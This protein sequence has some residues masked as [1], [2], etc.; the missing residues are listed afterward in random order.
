LEIE[1]KRSKEVDDFLS[2]FSKVDKIIKRGRFSS[3][4]FEEIDLEFQ[5]KISNY[6]RD[7]GLIFA[8]N[9]FR[10]SNA[11]RVPKTRPQILIG[12]AFNV[13]YPNMHSWPLLNVADVVCLTCN[14]DPY[15]FSSTIHCDKDTLFSNI[16]KQIPDGFQP[17]FYFDNQIEHGHFIPI[18]IEKAPFPIIASI[19]HI[20]Y[21]K[22]IGHVCE[23]FDYI[24]PV[25]RFYADILKKQYTEKILD[26]PFG[27]NWAAFSQYVNPVWEKTID[28]NVIF[29][30]T[31]SPI[32]AYKRNIV[33]ELARKF[34]DKYGDRFSIKI[35][36]SLPYKDY[37][38]A[39]QK[40][41]ITVNAVGVNGSY[42]YRTVEAMCTGSMVFQYEYEKGDFFKNSFN[43]L[44][45]DG[46]HG[47]TFNFDN[48]ETKLLYYLENQDITKRIAKAGYSYL[49]TRLTYE[50]LYA[51]LI[52]DVKKL[53]LKRSEKH[54]PTRG[55]H[56]VAM[57]YY[58][59]NELYVPELEIAIEPSSN[60]MTWIDL[61]N[62]MISSS[63]VTI[64]ESH[65]PLII[66]DPKVIAKVKDSSREDLYCKL[67]EM[68]LACTPEEYCWILQWN[69]LL[70]SLEREKVSRFEI[71]EML[72]QLENMQP[73]PFDEMTIIFKYEVHSKLFPK[74]Y[75]GSRN[76]AFINLNIE[77]IKANDQPKERALCYSA[78]AI[79]ALKY[80]LQV[81]TN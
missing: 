31:D 6:P 38:G 68:A 81:Y 1:I 2:Y 50:K 43:E 11:K 75:F 40:S 15:P 4:N 12:G 47:A 52:E 72:I 56:H 79:N 39:L 58:Y 5:K 65:L 61:N 26:F 73:V 36:P 35:L 14:K 42:N 21:H 53:P 76:D 64:A 17:D 9:E 66:L 59:Q 30:E 33:L 62:L 54:F 63:H 13:N 23:L 49:T 8:Y 22:T 18:G 78:Y 74:Y 19:C 57:T 34:E 45:I 28:V 16:L 69:Y 41:R 60:L 77:L 80:F 46:V 3:I 51:K 20:Y 25:G 55:R 24:I 29:N 10:V 37:I 48:F 7:L 70:I 67:Y 32:Y 44:F 71:E 27:L